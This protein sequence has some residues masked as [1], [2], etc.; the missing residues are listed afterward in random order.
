[1]EPQDKLQ[2]PAA[3]GPTED[4]DS[5]TLPPA[6]AGLKLQNLELMFHRTSHAHIETHRTTL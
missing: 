5:G 4:K 6:L 3:Q 2:A 1:M